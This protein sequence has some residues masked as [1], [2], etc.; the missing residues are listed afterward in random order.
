MAVEIKVKPG[1]QSRVIHIHFYE[2]RSWRIDILAHRVLSRIKTL[3]H[4]ENLRPGA[5]IKLSA[6]PACLGL[7]AGNY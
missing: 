3:L 4:V 7:I 1:M 6:E 5:E 2:R